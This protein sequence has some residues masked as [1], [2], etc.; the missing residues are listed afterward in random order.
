MG[1]ENTPNQRLRQQQK[2]IFAELSLL[3]V[4][5][6][7]MYIIYYILLK[8]ELTFCCSFS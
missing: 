2:N 7:N 4:N 6:I 1:I 5:N 8:I 3:T